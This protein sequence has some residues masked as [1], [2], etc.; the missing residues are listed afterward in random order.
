M[1]SRDGFYFGP[2]FNFGTDTPLVIKRF[3]G[4]GPIPSDAIITEGGDPIITESGDF[5]VTE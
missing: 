1:Q 2:K 4:S 3:G 5:I